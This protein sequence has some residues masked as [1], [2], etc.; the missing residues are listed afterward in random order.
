MDDHY[1]NTTTI[2]LFYTSTLTTETLLHVSECLICNDFFHH[3]GLDT[4]YHL[5][6]HLRCIVSALRLLK[7]H[8]IARG[9]GTMAFDL[10]DRLYNRMSKW[11]DYHKAEPV[12][13]QGGRNYERTNYNNEFLLV[14][15]TDLISSLPSDRTLTDH[16]SRRVVAGLSAISQGASLIFGC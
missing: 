8:G 7:V 10:F 16:I 12:R 6:L 13:D 5:E 4:P 11:R 2:G 9:S 14:Y 1:Y 3:H 15:A